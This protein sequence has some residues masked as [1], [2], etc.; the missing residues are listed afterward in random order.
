[1]RIENENWE[2]RN[3]A[4]VALKTIIGKTKQFQATRI[5]DKEWEG[6]LI[7]TIQ[8]ILITSGSDLQEDKIPVTEYTL[9]QGQA[10][11]K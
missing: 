4:L 11:N 5:D 6:N 3:E 9:S 7:Q 8:F 1:M 10:N 2:K